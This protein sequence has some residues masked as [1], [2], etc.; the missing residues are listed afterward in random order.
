MYHIDNVW[1][2]VDTHEQEMVFL[3]T[4]SNQIWLNIISSFID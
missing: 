1:L 3:A 4:V 2:F